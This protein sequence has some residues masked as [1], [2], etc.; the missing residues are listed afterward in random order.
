MAATVPTTALDRL[1]GWVAP[2]AGVRRLA[3][4]RMLHKQ[5]AYEGASTKDGWIPRRAGAS[6]DADHSADGRM[7][8]TRARSLV[9]NNPYAR[10]ALTS[11][12]ANVVG[13]GIMPQSR[14]SR[15]AVREKLDALFEQWSEQCDADGNLDFA[16]LTALCYRAMEQDGEVL[17]RLRPRRPED[18]LAVPL[19]LQVL[20][21]DYLDSNKTGLAETG[22]QIINGIQY[23]T[24]GRKA[25]YWLFDQHPGSIGRY[26]RGQHTSRFVAAEGVIHLYTPERPGQGRGITRFAPVIAL[27][28][29]LAIYED[30]ELARKQNESLLSVIVSGDGADLATGDASAMNLGSLG[31]LRPGAVLSTN[32]HHVTVA[33]PAAVGGYA[34]YIRMR[35]YA[36]AA[37]FGVTYEMLTGDLSQ[38][39]FSSARVGLLEFRRHAEQMQWHILV[40]RLLGPIWRAFVAAARTGGQVA[41]DDAAVEWTTPKWQYVN[42][43]QDVRADRMEIEAGMASISEKLRQRGYQPKRVFDELGEDLR[44]LQ[45][46]GVLDLLALFS[47]RRGAGE[48]REAS[49]ENTEP[50]K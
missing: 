7:L 35:L 34:E 2:G 9:Q 48:G 4:R 42:P 31:E 39:N 13:E 47:G 33:Q 14:A 50:K 43:Q 16:G 45:G 20:E 24:L 8:R 36:A 38:V 46:A 6:A 19:Q 26:V 3:A 11:L 27:L 1:I 29:D 30:A 49:I 17:I 18:G 12:V 40:P 10:K 5:R 41:E 44:H 21:I 25:G 22:D 23:D 28:R 37:G 15:P 32:G